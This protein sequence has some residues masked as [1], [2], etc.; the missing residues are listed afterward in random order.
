MRF[1]LNGSLTKPAVAIFGEFDPLTYEHLDLIKKL[2]KY[3]KTKNL[4]SLVIIPYPRPIDYIME[5]GES[6][7]Y[8]DMKFIKEVML[9]KGINAVLFAYFNKYDAHSD[10]TKFMPKL[11]KNVRLQEFWIGES[12]SFGRG[13]GGTQNSV[14]ELSKEYN[15]DVKL[16]KK[17]DCCFN[18]RNILGKLELGKFRYDSKLLPYPPT[19]RKTKI[20]Y[21]NCRWRMRSCKVILTN[22]IME[23]PNEIAK[24]IKI[25]TEKINDTNIKIL[26]PSGNYKYLNI[27]SSN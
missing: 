21:L 24:I 17:K 16:L 1:K 20:G 5:R 22:E 14:I 12:Q 4:S 9:N 25:K 8:N 23:K 10:M 13:M 19:W 15:F 6:I 7:Y 18:P 3:S 11:I 27:I 26:F 2:V